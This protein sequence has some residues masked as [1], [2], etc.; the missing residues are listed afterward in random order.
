M[1]K[2]YI[3]KDE[4]ELAIIKSILES[5]EIPFYVRNEYF[6]SLY[7][8]VALGSF[9]SKPIFVP[10]DFYEDAKEILSE[11]VSEDEFEPL[12]EDEEPTAVESLIGS[13]YDYFFKKKS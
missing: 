8:G 1:I 6:G 10:E 5:A 7:M 11:L 13:V 2:L 12:V 4:S 9:N 3:P